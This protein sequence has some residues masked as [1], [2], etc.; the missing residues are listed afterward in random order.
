M[1][2]LRTK[3]PRFFHHSLMLFAVTDTKKLFHFQTPP[4]K[5]IIHFYFPNFYVFFHVFSPCFVVHFP[6][7]RTCR[8]W[9]SSLGVSKSPWMLSAAPQSIVTVPPCLLVG[10]WPTPLKNGV[11]V[12]WMMTFHSQY[13]GK[14]M[15][16]S[17]VPNHQPAIWGW[18]TLTN[19]YSSGDD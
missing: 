13:D 15:A 10:G 3:I 6:Q 5:I 11:K 2:G 1:P 16:N 18:L 8:R 17:M 19:H 9:N 12:S 7:S 14:V 4:N